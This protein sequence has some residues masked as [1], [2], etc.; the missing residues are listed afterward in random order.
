MSLN[1]KKSVFVILVVVAAIAGCA[2]RTVKTAAPMSNGGSMIAIEAR[3]FKFSPNE[4]RVE[5]TG[6]LAIEIKNGSGSV[7]NFTLKDP[8]GKVLKNKDI[9]PGGSVILN[10][11]L[12]D[13]GVYKFY[14]GKHFHS[15]LG[16]NGIIVVGRQTSK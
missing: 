3:S 6:L 16:M 15:T 4:I 7:H 14:C 8:R 1:S 11:E 5:K 2:G 13:P 12:P 10:V 9:S